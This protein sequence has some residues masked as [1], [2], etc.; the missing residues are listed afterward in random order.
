MSFYGHGTVSA[1][2][3]FQL[4]E[5]KS[6]TICHRNCDTWT[7]ALDNSETCWNRISLGFSQTRHIVTFWLL[8]LRSFFTYLLTYNNDIDNHQTFSSLL[9]GNIIQWNNMYISEWQI[10]N[11][12]QHS[13]SCQDVTVYLNLLPVVAWPC[14]TLHYIVADTKNDFKEPLRRSNIHGL[15]HDWPPRSTQ[16]GHPTRSTSQ[17]AVLICTMLICCKSED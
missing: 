10:Y 8:R 12:V 5:I 2:E 3:P 13:Q 6:G 4:P 7:S 16:P 11:T 1:T 9:T 15:V 14:L 17:W